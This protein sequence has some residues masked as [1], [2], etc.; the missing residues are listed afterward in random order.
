MVGSPIFDIQTKT[1]DM[2]LKH[3]GSSD[4]TGPLLAFSCVRNFVLQR[5][6]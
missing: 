1:N 5:E 4:N 2:E 3:Q 6:N